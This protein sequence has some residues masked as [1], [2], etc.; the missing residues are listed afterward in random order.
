MQKIMNHPMIVWCVIAGALLCA[1][2][3]RAIERYYN[4]S[5]HRDHKPRHI[6]EIGKDKDIF[7][8]PGDVDEDDDF[9]D[10]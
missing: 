8:L 6:L 9:E 5:R 10:L 7:Y 2:L 4:E 1:F 3:F